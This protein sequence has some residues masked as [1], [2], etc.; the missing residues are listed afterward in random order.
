MTS[1]ELSALLLKVA[2]KSPLGATIRMNVE[3]HPPFFVT[4]L[5][6]VVGVAHEGPDTVATTFGLVEGDLLA[7]LRGDLSPTQAFMQGRMTIEGDMTIAM[8]LAQL[9]VP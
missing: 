2:A 5:P 6:G 4:S 3:E 1:A 7:I 8:R 9:I